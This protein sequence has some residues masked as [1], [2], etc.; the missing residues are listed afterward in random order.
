LVVPEDSLVHDDGPPLRTVPPRPT[1]QHQLP[2]T[3][4]DTPSRSFAV[5][6]LWGDHWDPPSLVVRI[7]PPSP[8]AT[9]ELADEHDT[10]RK[11]WVVPDCWDDQDRPP[12]VV[13][14]IV[15][16]LPTDQHVLVEAGAHVM[17]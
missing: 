7:T 4:Q 16:A 9:Q 5:P 2:P 13:A 15:P 12:L 8:T 11:L 3:G 10:A 17:P 6:E 14:R 1:A